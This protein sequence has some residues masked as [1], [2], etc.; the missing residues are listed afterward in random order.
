M[1][2]CML[3]ID[4]NCPQDL[5]SVMMTNRKQMVLSFGGGLLPYHWYCNSQPLVSVHI[6]IKGFVCFSLSLCIHRY[7][8][9]AKVVHFLG[10]VK[11]WNYSY[12]AQ[13]DEVRGHSLS[14]DPCQ[15]YPDY[16]LMWW[17][18]YTKSVLPLLQQAYGDAPFCS[19]C[20]EENKDVSLCPNLQGR[21]DLSSVRPALKTCKCVMVLQL[22][23]GE[24]AGKLQIKICLVVTVASQLC[25]ECMNSLL[26]VM[27]HPESIEQL[28][29][30]KLPLS[31]L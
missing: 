14:A 20:I 22:P 30:R 23:G 4:W 7:G 27:Q 5:S 25:P 29:S 19:G 8:R 9:D 28:F 16:L 18:L 12:D 26:S 11:P 10:N 17:Q 31:L 3:H 15:L 24:N 1:G 6:V 2:A 21:G 13:R